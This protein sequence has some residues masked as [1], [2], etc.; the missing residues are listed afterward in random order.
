M[1]DQSSMDVD[2][3]AEELASSL[4]VPKTKV[5]ADI[6]EFLKYGVPVEEAVW[7]V[8]DKYEW[9][10]L[11]LGKITTARD[12][13]LDEI[14]ITQES[15]SV[16]VRILTKG[17]RTV[18]AQGEEVILIE[19]RFADS[20]GVMSYTTYNGFDFEVGDSVAIVNAEVREWN[21]DCELFLNQST[22]VM[23]A[24][25]EVTVDQPIGGDTDLSDLSV[26]DHGRNIEARILDIKSRTDGEDGETEVLEGVIADRTG[27]LPFIDEGSHPKLET[28]RK[29]R[30][31]DVYVRRSDG[32]PA[33]TLTEFSTVSQL[34][35]TVKEIDSANIVD[36]DHEYLDPPPE[37]G[38]S[39]IA[40]LYEIQRELREE[41]I[42]PFT[43]PRYD[44][45][46][47]SKPNGVLFSGPPGTGK[48]HVARALAGELGYNFFEVDIGLIQDSEF[49]GTQE[50]ITEVFETAKNSQPCVVFLDELDSIAP[51]RDSHLHQAR[52]EAVNQ[53]LR[54]IGTIN[55]EN[56]DVVII[57]ATNRGDQIDDALQRTG[58]FDTR[59]KIGM[60]DAETRIAILEQELKSFDGSVDPVWSDEEFE[61]TFLDATSNFASSDIIEVVDSA[62]RAS[63]R[64]TDPAKEPH[65]SE[66]IIMD[67]VH[68]VTGK[69]EADTA[70]EYLTETPSIDFS[71]VGGMSDTK[72]RLEEILL[73]PLSEPELYEEY[74]LE[75]PNGVLLY[76][77]PGTG[78]TYISRALA[79]EADCAFVSITAAD[80]VSKWIGE[81]AQ[82]IKG[83]FEK[84]KNVA[85]AIV[86]IDEIDAV[87]N[88]R[89]SHMTH[90]EQQAVNE[91]ITQISNLNQS[92]VFVIGTTNRPKIIDKALTR[93]GRLGE[94][95]EVPPPDK[96]TS[97]KILRKQLE[98]RPLDDDGIDW[99]VIEDCLV[100][101][102][103]ATSYVA[104]DLAKIADEAVR[105][106]M[107]EAEVG[108]L[109]PVTQDHIERAITE[110]EPSLGDLEVE[111]H[112][113]S[114]QN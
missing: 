76:G 14:T 62:Q 73:D 50:N 108:D 66:E 27:R 88:S 63:L 57:G 3:K 28:G 84:A 37:A 92:D 41:I 103:D 95:I 80:I 79:G 64:R 113:Q 8:R 13:Y 39:N 51:K 44:E 98:D 107:A 11:Y 70:G 67:R 78:K 97:L 25:Q 89:D 85:P 74:G 109:Q 60:P 43:D 59:I 2:D 106:A 22:S 21:D 87:A 40:G 24:D 86:F 69:Q 77:P 83:L 12:S 36:S 54:H 42:E 46:N 18:T 34:S 4:V 55:E 65:I 53:L 56:M 35:P 91:L 16:A 82:N 7:R 94:T 52:A 101:E 112:A 17:K 81:A 102:N 1:T 30:I 49:G 15:A 45:Y 93:A 100:V 33:V 68:A 10:T 75:I 9:W 105:Y 29:V 32:S 48:T 110:T 99:N 96:T 61:D 20:T 31:E 6:E 23:V 38:F 72:T 19:G 111:Q 90:S 71:D 114:R 47:V 5:K 26:G 58:R 104:S